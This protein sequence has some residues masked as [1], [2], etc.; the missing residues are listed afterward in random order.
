MKPATFQSCLVDHRLMLLADGRFP[1]GGHAH[2]SGLEAA[3]ADG[4]VRDLRDLRSYLQGWLFCGLEAEARLAGLAADPVRC[5]GAGELTMLDAE[6]EAA[7]PSP[8]VRRTGRTLG[9]A[10]LR[11]SSRIWPD[12][13]RLTGYLDAVLLNAA[14]GQHPVAFGVSSAAC[15]GGE[16]S[17]VPAALAYIYNAVTGA[18]WSAVR[19]LPVDPVDIARLIEQLQPAFREVA[20]KASGPHA[21]RAGFA[22][23]YEMRAEEH[24]RWEVRLFAS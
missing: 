20:E 4:A 23:A 3:S 22:P 8:A 12:D 16:I 6:A 11:N 14:A 9:R 24:A 7:Q 17:P 13:R 18:A 1:S 10:L 15:L 19:L 5:P 21:L 2:S